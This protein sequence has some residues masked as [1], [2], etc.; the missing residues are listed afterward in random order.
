[1]IWLATICRTLPWTEVL[2]DNILSS[3]GHVCIEN[4]EAE[5]EWQMFIVGISQEAYW[6]VWQTI[7]HR[8]HWEAIEIAH[9]FSRLR[10]ALS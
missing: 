6:V 7:P 2:Y 8:D 1:M 5:E 9:T 3:D 10:R 4:Y